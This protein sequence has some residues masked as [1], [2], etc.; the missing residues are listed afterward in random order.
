MGRLESRGFEALGLGFLALI[1]VA[2]P[3]HIPLETTETAD[4]LADDVCLDPVGPRTTPVAPVGPPD[5]A[6]DA[7][8]PSFSSAPESP[9]PPPA[10]A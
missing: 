2:A 5:R 1:L 6:V 8:S 7:S 4:D 10:H 9:R 3:L